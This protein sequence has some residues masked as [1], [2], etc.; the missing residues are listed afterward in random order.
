MVMAGLV[1]AIH[2]FLVFLLV[3]AGL[4]P[5]IHEAR[6]RIQLEYIRLPT[7]TASSWM[8]GSSPRMTGW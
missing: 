6:L 4:D 8:R 1:P 7:A 2:V 3:I 5:A